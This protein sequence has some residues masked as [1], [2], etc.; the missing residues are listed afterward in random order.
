MKKFTPGAALAAGLVALGLSMGQAAAQD[1]PNRPIELVVPFNAGGSA[2]GSARPLAESLSKRLGQP[3]V[4]ENRPGAQSVIGGGYVAQSD[5]DGY[6]LLYSAGGTILAP[7]LV[8]DMPFDPIGGMTAVSIVATFPYVVIAGPGAPFKDFQG[9][10]DYARANPGKLS[11]AAS[12]PVTTANINLMLEALGV[13]MT[14]VNYT[15]G[16]AVMSDLLGGHVA[17]SLVGA[18]AYL[19]Q[20]ENDKVTGIVSTSAERIESLKDLPTLTELGYKDLVIDSFYGISG[21]K[22]MDPAAVEKLQAE[23]GAALNDPQ[24]PLRSQLVNLGFE[25]QEDLSSKA[26][27][28][29]FD[30]YSN[31]MK[32]VFDKLG[33]KPE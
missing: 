13:E 32:Q 33:I 28:D 24:D 8:K 23:I 3:V 19:P 30:V 7:F 21:P 20:K 10:M 5:P 9:M 22:D 18:G 17:L 26:A 11:I 12:D 16:G 1:Y 15:G 31:Q 4:V 6:T 27:L 29:K 25:I 14:V 2:D